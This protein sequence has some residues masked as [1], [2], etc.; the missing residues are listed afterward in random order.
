VYTEHE[1]YRKPLLHVAVS[2]IL[3]VR[4][5]ARLV[6]ICRAFLVLARCVSLLVFEPEDGSI[7]F[8]SNVDGVTSQD[9]VTGSV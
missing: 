2:V 7:M 6:M 8:L 9:R 1:A 3:G 4:F 5:S